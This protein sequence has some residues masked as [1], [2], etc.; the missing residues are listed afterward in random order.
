MRGE[1][2]REKREDRREKIEERREKRERERER[3]AGVTP[4]VQPTTSLW[5]IRI[6][7]F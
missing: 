1:R 7:S 3:D 6:S 2:E 4:I 5:E